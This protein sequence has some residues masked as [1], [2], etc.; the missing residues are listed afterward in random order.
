MSA[1]VSDT[2]PLHYL[3]ECE[4]VHILPAL[5]GEVLIP[6]TVHRELQHERTPPL[7]RGWA[8]ALP[9]WI[10]VQVP[11]FIDAAL[12]VDEGEREAICLAREVK[13][14]VLLIDDRRGR[15]EAVRCGLRVTGTIGLLEAAASRGLVDFAD[16]IQRLRRTGARLDSELV[17]AALRRNR[18]R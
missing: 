15:T 5:F 14:V 10:K 2:S 3:I 11:K 1:V 16:S 17:Q 13:A 18:T 12:N 6:P 7:V 9:G 4:A 8:Q